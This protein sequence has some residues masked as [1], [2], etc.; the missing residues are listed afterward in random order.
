M[1]FFI[2]PN[3]RVSVTVDGGENVVWVR[4]KMDVATKARVQDALMAINGIRSDGAVD[5][6]TMAL[7]LNQQNTILLQNNILSW[8]GPM[9]RDEAGH[10]VPC[11]PE[12]I[13]TIDPDHPLLEAIL[14]RLNEL[15][16]APAQSNGKSPLPV[17]ALSGDGKSGSSPK[18]STQSR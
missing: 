18:R 6:V 16:K 13:E 3:D 7:T 5:H 11:T 1:G 9:F 17:A 4:R 12:A 15:N 10:S 8:E 14:T 2:S